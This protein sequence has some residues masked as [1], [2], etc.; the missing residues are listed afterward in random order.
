MWILTDLFLALSICF[1]YIAAIE[2]S[3]TGYLSPRETQ[4]IVWN[5]LHSENISCF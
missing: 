2:L 5:I 4:P 3:Q 1:S